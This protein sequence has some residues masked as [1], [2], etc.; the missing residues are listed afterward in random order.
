MSTEVGK[1]VEEDWE[2]I[3]DAGNVESLEPVKGKITQRIK[4]FDCIYCSK[5]RIHCKKYTP[6]ISGDSDTKRVFC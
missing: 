2:T 4:R 5:S 6:W 3:A 1:E